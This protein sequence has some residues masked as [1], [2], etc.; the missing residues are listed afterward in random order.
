MF[1]MG[2]CIAFFIVMGDLGSQ[3]IGDTFNIKTTTAFRS[4][5]MI[6]NWF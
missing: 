1:L 5:I 2:T 4:S 6:G 3:I